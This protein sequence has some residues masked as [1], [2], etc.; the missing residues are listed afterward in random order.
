MDDENVLAC[1][2]VVDLAVPKSGSV[3]G[4]H[5]SRCGYEVWVMR[6]N[7]GHGLTLLCRSCSAGDLARRMLAGEV[8][9]VRSAEG[10]S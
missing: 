8:V 3:R 2:R 4:H 10:F 5:C 9:E 7:L 1:W 6:K